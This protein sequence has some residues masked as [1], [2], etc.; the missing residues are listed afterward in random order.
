LV[1]VKEKRLPIL[2]AQVFWKLVRL[3]P[4]GETAH[5]LVKQIKQG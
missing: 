4:V 2:G 1:A 3:I 5:F